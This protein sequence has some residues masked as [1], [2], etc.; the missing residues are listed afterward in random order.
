MG[1][2]HKPIYKRW[3]VWLIAVFLVFALVNNLTAKTPDSVAATVKPTPSAQLW[4]T[5]DVTPASVTRAID[6]AHWNRSLTGH[7]ISKITVTDG[8][9]AIYVTLKQN[10]GPADE[11]MQASN[12][13]VVVAEILFR[14][15][16][17][18][19]IGVWGDA[20]FSDPKGNDVTDAAVKIIWNRDVTDNVNWKKYR[21]TVLLDYRKPFNIATAYTIND[22]TYGALSETD[23]AGFPKQM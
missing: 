16:A 11:L 4:E 15:P 13:M 12:T 9:V 14:N 22:A 5:A 2:V 19:S 21:D 18:K 6:G 20:V 3:W 7:D 17:V 8:S 1:R 23:R 10:Y